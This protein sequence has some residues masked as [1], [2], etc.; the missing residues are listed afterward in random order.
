MHDSLQF[1]KIE[2]LFVVCD[3]I[4][5]EHID[6]FIGMELNISYGHRIGLSW[7]LKWI[8]ML[9]HPA[10]IGLDPNLLGLLKTP[11]LFQ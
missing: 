8:H 2:N 6:S 3:V 10:I 1:G 5:S 11:G 7:R 9:K 4:S